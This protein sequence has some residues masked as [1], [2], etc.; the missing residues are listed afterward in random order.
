MTDAFPKQ[1]TA[2]EITQDG[3]PEVLVPC[4]MATPQP[5]PEEVLIHIAAAGVNR[6]DV[7]QRQGNYPAPKGASPIPGLEV[8]G[9]IA[10]LGRNTSRYK[11]GDKVC[12]LVTG[13]G[14]AQYCV[15]HETITLPIPGSLS[16]VEAAGLPETCFTVWANV[17]DRAN[18]QPD[19]TLLV[20]GGSSG[21]GTTAIQMATQLLGTDVFVTAGSDEKCAMCE[22]L[23]A[24]RAINYKE[25]D[26][27]EIVKAD[28]GGKGVDVILDMIGGD[29]IARNL[30]A[31]APDGRIVNIAF[32]KGAK[33]EVNFLP[34]M[35][36]R[37]TLTGSTLRARPVEEKAQI[38]RQLE[39]KI[40]P[41]I[42]SG[43]IHP[44]IHA[45][46]PLAHAA[47]AHKLM[48]SSAHIGK[49]ILVTA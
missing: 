46:F 23:G 21:I 32:L 22:K 29:Y 15:A 11:V 17:F 27:V 25:Q 4:E 48:E 1:M 10:A 7:F 45:E 9:T 42:A 2:I 34:I 44:V 6:P 40:W 30:K 43:K 3:G 28:T 37:L 14:Y 47:D 5:G 33:A 12:A 8:A 38:A 49:I 31:A 18:L 20:H 24:K 26:F 13:G 35:L 36:K 16:M 41:L 19:E 39:E